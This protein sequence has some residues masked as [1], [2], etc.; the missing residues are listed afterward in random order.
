MQISQ[1]VGHVI[2][3]RIDHT[4]SIHITAHWNGTTRIGRPATSA[5]HDAHLFSTTFTPSQTA[6]IRPVAITV[7][8]ALNV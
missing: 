3:G 2:V 1:G 4:N 6:P 5:P 8:T 7:I